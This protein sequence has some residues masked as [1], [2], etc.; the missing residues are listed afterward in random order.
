MRFKN[1]PAVFV[2][3]LAIGM[4]PLA[5]G[6]DDVAPPGDDGAS[7]AGAQTGGHS[8]TGGAPGGEGGA[9]GG[10]ATTG[11]TSG[12]ATGGKSTGGSATGGKSTGGSAT[13]GNAGSSSGGAG[14]TSGGEGGASG[15]SDG[16]TGGP[17]AGGEG[18]EGGEGWYDE[19]LERLKRI[20]KKAEPLGCEHHADCVE[21]FRWL[22]S[23]TPTCQEEAERMLICIDTQST[24]EDFGCWYGW[25]GFIVEDTCRQEFEPFINRCAW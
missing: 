24:T 6:E 8:A 14:A 15:A 20:C 13:G 16:G 11:G 18:G 4:L 17:S 12:S 1:L 7:G 25:P 3:S 23:P 19:S 9:T 5:C 21:T 22:F 10:S 2:A